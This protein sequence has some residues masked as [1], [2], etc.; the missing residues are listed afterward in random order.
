MT[1]EDLEYGV[2]SARS[3]GDSGDRRYDL[4]YMAD[5]DPRVFY[6]VSEAGMNGPWRALA[7]AVKNPA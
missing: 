2:P 7:P 3:H 4:V 5:G 6:G 1:I